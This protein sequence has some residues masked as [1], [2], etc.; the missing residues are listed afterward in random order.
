MFL[1]FINYFLL[2]KKI[3]LMNEKKKR[4][5]WKDIIN[6]EFEN[7]LTQ[8]KMEEKLNSKKKE[9]KKTI[10]A[11]KPIEDFKE[12]IGNKN[13]DLTIPA[14]NLMSDLIHKFMRDSF[15]GSYYIKTIECINV[16]RDA[17][18]EEDKVEFFNNFLNDLKIK[19]PKELFL[20]FWLLF[21]FDKMFFIFFSIEFF[22]FHQ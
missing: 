10:S 20:D 21:I 18:N 15:K 9:S 2:K 16:Y 7:K 1:F 22:I 4:I 13:N 12:M 19:N 17:A 8:E 14:M 11:I 3:E 6:E 5:F